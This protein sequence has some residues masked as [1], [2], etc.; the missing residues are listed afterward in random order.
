[1]CNRDKDK[2]N[3]IFV[4]H[5]MT[6]GN[7]EK[8]YIGRTNEPLCSEG[9]L[10]LEKL[11]D[12]GIYKK[13]ECV[14]VSPMLRCLQTLEIIYPEV[15]YGD[16]SYNESSISERS[17]EEKRKQVLNYKKVDDFRECDFGIF[18]GKNYIELSDEPLYQKW[19]DS[20]AVLPFPKGE[21]RED[22]TARCVRAFESIAEELCGKITD[23]AENKTYQAAF[24]VH[25]GTIM[26][27]LEHFGNEGKGYYDYRCR[28][29]EGYSC[30]LDKTEGKIKLTCIQ[31][32]V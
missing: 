8:R 19:I 2:I 17:N 30:I 1:M 25:G 22:F 11:K 26:S 21:A 18:E 14:Y 31:P 29:G 23:R 13:A 10:A 3:I 7:M 24:I 9:R 5:G 32:L 16:K 4:R 15:Y 27:I 28:N 6:A 20:N 12:S